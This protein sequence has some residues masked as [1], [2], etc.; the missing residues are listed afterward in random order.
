MTT[1]TICSSVSYN[2]NA[3]AIAPVPAPSVVDAGSNVNKHAF[4]LTVSP[5]TGWAKAA[6]RMGTDGV[7]YPR[8]GEVLVSPNSGGA[9]ASAAGGGGEQPPARYFTG[10]IL[11]VGPAGATATLTVT[12]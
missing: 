1:S 11:E 5:T 7:N 8:G 6:T 2:Q 3:G 12:Y 10:E 9:S 4:T